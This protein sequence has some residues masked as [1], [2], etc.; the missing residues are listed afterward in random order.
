MKIISDNFT[1][2]SILLEKSPIVT[3]A[4]LLL[5]T[6]KEFMLTMLSQ[7]KSIIIF[8]FGVWKA[9]SKRQI[10]RVNFHQFSIIFFFNLFLH[11]YWADEIFVDPIKKQ[12]N[13]FLYTK[14]FL[15]LIVKSSNFTIIYI[16]STVVAKIC[17]VH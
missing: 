17:I 1:N 3:F 8:V 13:I 5:L 11:S 16:A 6:A 15:D 10:F 14:N 7:S 12:W 4:L 9:F 2:I